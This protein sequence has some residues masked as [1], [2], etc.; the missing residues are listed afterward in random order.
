MPYLLS[1][2]WK[3]VNSFQYKIDRTYL[4]YTKF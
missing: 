1:N 3:P 4:I 2:D